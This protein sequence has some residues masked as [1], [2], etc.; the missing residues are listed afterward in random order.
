[1]GPTQIDEP[2]PS[3][4]RE[5][6]MAPRAAETSSPKTHGSDEQ[7]NCSKQSLNEEEP[8]LDTSEPEGVRRIL[9]EW[10]PLPSTKYV[11]GACSNSI[12]SSYIFNPKRLNQRELDESWMSDN[13][14]YPQ[15][16]SKE[17]VQTVFDHP[18]YLTPCVHLILQANDGA[19]TKDNACKWFNHTSKMCMLVHPKYTKTK[20]N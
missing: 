19:N 11:K 16:M 14:F 6:S 10:Q 20:R 3:E 9:T 4:Q 17:L 18:T 15:S 13:H 1:M 2:R 8:S 5:P 7:F 12:W